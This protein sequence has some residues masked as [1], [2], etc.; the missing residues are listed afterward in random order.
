M[1]V[2]NFS[3]V[4]NW[5]LPFRFKVSFSSVKNFLT[6]YTSLSFNVKSINKP[7]FPLGTDSINQNYGTTKF[8]MPTFEFDKATLDITFVEEDNSY[9]QKVLLSSLGNAMTNSSN[10]IF[11]KIEEYDMALTTLISTRIYECQLKSVDMPE[12]SRSGSASIMTI[13]AHYIVQSIINAAYEKSDLMKSL[14]GETQDA[15]QDAIENKQ[16]EAEKAAEDGDKPQTGTPNKSG[17]SSDQLQSKQPAP[18]DPKQKKPQTELTDP[19][20]KRALTSEQKVKVRKLHDRAEALGLL[21]SEFAKNNT[22][23]KWEKRFSEDINR[24]GKGDGK[25]TS[26]SSDEYVITDIDA[27]LDTALTTVEEMGRLNERLK[28]ENYTVRLAGTHDNYGALFGSHDDKSIHNNGGKADMRP[29]HIGQEKLSESIDMTSTEGRDFLRT[30]AKTSGDILKTAVAET[31]GKEGTK[32][33]VDGNFTLV[34]DWNGGTKTG[35]DTQGYYKPS[36]G[37][38]EYPKN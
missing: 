6:E 24:T 8:V 22:A 7:R 17:P 35:I 12:Y 25:K 20:K 15:L 4:T 9:M 14:S 33:W 19:P 32:G 29:Y 37:F 18:E 13:T 26:K 10:G 34:S 27:A 28:S 1:N 16:K 23:D 21:D 31:S 36:S 11:V 2:Y 3:K 38:H 5:H 30:M